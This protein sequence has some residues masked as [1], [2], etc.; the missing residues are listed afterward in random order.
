MTPAEL[1]VRERRRDAAR[2]FVT[3]YDDASGGRVEL[4]IA[5]TVN[6]ANKI[7]GHL[8]DELEVEPGSLLRPT[9]APH[10]VSAVLLLGTWTAGA[11]V[12]DDATALALEVDADPM[13]AALS[14]LVG[15]QPDE[16]SAG[17]VDPAMPALVLGG[18]SWTHEE[19][20]AA[21][22]HD[23][24]EHGLDA[25]S[26]V[27][28]ILG[29]DS[30]NGIDAGLLVPLAAGGSVVLVADVDPDRLPD[31]CVTERVTHT[32]GVGVAGLPRLC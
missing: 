2:P 27:L 29:Y 16:F 11:A 28:S 21:A 3:W 9:T 20:G 24:A 22:A 23:A 5:T 13:G 14:R 26:R 4:S 6:W 12:S 18:R 15:G 1:L 17:A 25:T 32:A 19:L 7:A 10:W 31:R 30:A 8:V